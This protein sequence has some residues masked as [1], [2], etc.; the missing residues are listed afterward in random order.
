[1]SNKPGP[2]H[3]NCIKCGRWRAAKS[4]F[5]K[6]TA[7]M[8][9]PPLM[10]VAESPGS[11][12]DAR[13]TQ[14]CG[15]SGNLFWG[16]AAK[17]GY[18]RDEVARQNTV[19]C[20]TSKPT[21]KEMR[22]CRP[23]LL[24]DIEKVKPKKIMALGQWAGRALQNDGTCTVKRDRNRILTVPDLKHHAQRVTLTYHPASILHGMD[25][26][27][28]HILA[29]M[30]RL[31]KGAKKIRP[32]IRQVKDLRE[33]KRLCKEFSNSKAFSFDLE[34]GRE[35][36]E[37][38]G[39]GILTVSICNDTRHVWW[40]AVEHKESPW[41][42]VKVQ[43]YLRILLGGTAIKVG[44]NLH[45]DMLKLAQFGINTSGR[46]IDT[47]ALFKFFDENYPDKSLEHI[48]ARF[49]GFP[50][51]AVYMRPWKRGIRMQVGTTKTGRPRYEKVIDFGL[52]PL[53]VLGTYNGWDAYAG[54]MLAR[55]LMKK[56]K[57][58]KWFP[59]F[60]MY[61]KARKILARNTHEGF[62]VDVNVLDAKQKELEAEA[63]KLKK[64]FLH[65]IAK[66]WPKKT[67]IRFKKGDIAPHEDDLRRLLFLRM[68]FKSVE[69]TKGGKRAVTKKVLTDLRDQ[70]K[71]GV[72]AMLIG[73]DARK[74]GKDKA[75]KG[76]RQ[77]DKLIGTFLKRLRARLVYRD[78]VRVGDVSLPAGWY[79]LPGYSVPG[80]RTFRLSSR[81]NIQQIP[82]SIRPA[83]VSRWRKKK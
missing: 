5:M 69:R 1:M 80:A 60:L 15:Q 43:Q 76:L 37:G 83:F 75:K 6:V 79:F 63:K 35:K 55:K 40:W 41:P 81:P 14:L 66:Y 22:L 34:W 64:Q 11:T 52:A 19:R 26:N 59:V 48:V 33:I 25:E 17:A 31:R 7:P 29:D 56:A 20:G 30:K 50:D 51:Y 71:T 72:I 2:K 12:E 78:R 62:L 28:Q 73:Q 9:N 39:G 42:W 32:N 70:D 18:P 8:Q 36:P 24:A 45:E 13:G 53:D 57:R 21:M 23:F 68:K 47:L 46:I 77:L 44:H 3:P 65:L 61:M 58:K 4:P 27:R 54:W 74:V 16:I 82:K 49:L 10:V 38:G 67:P